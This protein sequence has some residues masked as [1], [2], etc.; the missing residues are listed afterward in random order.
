[1]TPKVIGRCL[2]LAVLG[3]GYLYLDPKVVTFVWAFAWAV[4]LENSG[5]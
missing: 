4:N 1:M 5:E 3:L 2:G